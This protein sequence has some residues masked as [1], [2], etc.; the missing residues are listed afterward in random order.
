MLIALSG[1]RFRIFRLDHLE[2]SAPI[3]WGLKS[4]R[5]N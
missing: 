1:L 2:D 4:S 3:A 5:E